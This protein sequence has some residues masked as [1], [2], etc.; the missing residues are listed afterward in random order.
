MSI[1][2]KFTE[3][4]SAKNWVKYSTPT[5]FV[6]LKHKR[7]NAGLLTIDRLLEKLH[8]E[9]TVNSKVVALFALVTACCDWLI[10]KEGKASSRRRAVQRLLVLIIQELGDLTNDRGLFMTKR[11]AAELKA[12]IKQYRS[13]R[14]YSALSRFIKMKRTMT[15]S[16]TTNET[17]KEYL[18]RVRKE[19][20]QQPSFAPKNPHWNNVIKLARTRLG[21]SGGKRLVRSVWLETMPLKR[22]NSDEK[23]HLYGNRVMD[24]L[25]ED[26][27]RGQSFDMEDFIETDYDYRQKAEEMLKSTKGDIIKLK[28]SEESAHVWYFDDEDRYHHVLRFRGGVIS[29][30]GEDEVVVAPPSGKYLYAAD[31]DGNIYAADESKTP[32]LNLRHSSFMAGRD[33]MCAGFIRVRDGRIIVIDNESGHYCP[34]TQRLV[35]FVR[36][37]RIKYHLNLRNIRVH[38]V[39]TMAKLGSVAVS[40]AVTSL[41]ADEFLQCGGNFRRH[42]R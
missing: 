42:G 37:L 26:F 9:T 28:D 6:V 30:R 24:V 23:V 11:T 14:L 41:P 2:S 34:S 19:R 16:D 32:K 8:D 31:P 12:F 38:D 13:Q 33:V 22:P 39:V 5:S 18:D 7:K 20:A 10:N 3:I 21:T 25:D 17:K 1:N 29:Q 40:G 35:T 4:P 15:G 36:T 27:H